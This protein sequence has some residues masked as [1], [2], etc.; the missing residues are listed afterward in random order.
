M[1]RKI[2]VRKVQENF[3]KNEQMVFLRWGG[4]RVEVENKK[5][6]EKTVIENN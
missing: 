5:F 1:F 6:I 3:Q 4:L 2:A